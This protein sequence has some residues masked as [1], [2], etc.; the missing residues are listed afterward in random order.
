MRRLLIPTKGVEDW[1]RLLA[2][3]D[4]HWRQGKSAYELAAAWESA[5]RTERGLPEDVAAVLDQSDEL[6]GAQ[7]LIGIP[8]HQVSLEG[9][10]HASQTDLWAMLQTASHG[11]VSMA[12]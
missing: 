3:P 9:G 5:A 11:F 1:R 2:D 6:R 7:L 4:R 10:G 8:E 12:V